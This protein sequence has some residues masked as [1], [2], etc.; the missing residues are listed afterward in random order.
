MT[1]TATPVSDNTPAN[2]NSQ[3]VVVIVAVVVVI[4]A[5]SIRVRAH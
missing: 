4:A 1:V 5:S 2:C 3:V